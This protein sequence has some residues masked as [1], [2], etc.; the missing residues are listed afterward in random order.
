MPF[1]FFLLGVFISAM[2]FVIAYGLVAIFRQLEQQTAL[3]RCDDCVCA[4][5]CVA[6]HKEGETP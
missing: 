1:A 5:E 6:R 2:L 4:E 3:M